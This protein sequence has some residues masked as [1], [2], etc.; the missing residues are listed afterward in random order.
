[1][2]NRTSVLYKPL[3]KDDSTV[4]ST[5]IPLCTNDPLFISLKMEPSYQMNRES[6]GYKNNYYQF[7]KSIKG[8]RLNL[9]FA[10]GLFL[11]AV[12]MGILIGIALKSS[13]P[14]TPTYSFASKEDL[15][16]LQLLV[17]ESLEN[18]V[19]LLKDGD[20]QNHNHIQQLQKAI[21]NVEKRLNSSQSTQDSRANSTSDQLSKLQGR[22]DGLNKEIHHPV[23][24]YKHCKEDT[25]HCSIDPKKSRDYWRD[26]ATLSLPLSEEVCHMYD[27]LRLHDEFI[28]KCITG[29]EDY[30]LSM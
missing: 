30:T 13:P 1:M 25:E 4:T 27:C 23:S 7:R 28:L 29:L 8:I 3:P 15:K 5:D 6:S 14:S 10:I 12:V 9:K 11:V 16:D 21:G 17:N 24:I 20:E 22:V 18:V 19:Q 2:G 26:C